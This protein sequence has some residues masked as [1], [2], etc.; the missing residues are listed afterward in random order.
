MFSN[1][2]NIQQQ[3]AFVKGF[4]RLSLALKVSKMYKKLT[5][6]LCNY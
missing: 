6:K 1:T 3:K 2:A 4:A 5:I